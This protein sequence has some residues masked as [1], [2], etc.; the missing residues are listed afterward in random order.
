MEILEVGGKNPFGLFIQ[1]RKL[2]FSHSSRVANCI[3][4]PLKECP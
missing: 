4:Q 1:L 3:G 2:D